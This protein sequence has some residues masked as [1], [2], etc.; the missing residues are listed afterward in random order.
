M[1]VLK[2]NGLVVIATFKDAKLN[3]MAKLAD[4]TSDSYWGFKTV[5]HS[6]KAMGR[7][8]ST[9]FKNVDIKIYPN[10]TSLLNAMGIRFLV[11]TGRK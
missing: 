8:M 7:M 11:V 9:R 6:K 3:L 10:G 4:I 5:R 1:R 2:P